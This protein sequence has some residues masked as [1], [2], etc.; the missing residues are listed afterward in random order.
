MPFLDIP[1][2]FDR[3]EIE[4]LSEDFLVKA[5]AAVEPDPK[6]PI[7]LLV[8]RGDVSEVLVHACAGRRPTRPRVPGPGG[9]ASG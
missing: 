5:V 1:G 6:V 8:A 4:D 7:N 2:A 3:Q 9:N